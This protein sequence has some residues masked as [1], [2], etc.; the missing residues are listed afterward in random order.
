MHRNRTTDAQ[1]TNQPPRL[2][3]RTT[4]GN[5][6]HMR[7][8]LLLSLCRLHR[9]KQ[10]MQQGSG[11]DSPSAAAHIAP[12]GG[13][14]VSATLPGRPDLLRALADVQSAYSSAAEIPVVV[15]GGAR[16]R[17][18]PMC[19]RVCAARQ[20]LARQPLPPFSPSVQDS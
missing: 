9:S 18:L 14:L 17:G 7:V 8:P 20:W 1:C 5:T 12:E 4:H 3:R 2:H 15:A 16:A 13:R 10:P 11:S 19:A 6:D